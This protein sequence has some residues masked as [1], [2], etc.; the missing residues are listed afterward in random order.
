M[1]TIIPTDRFKQDMDYYERKKKFRHIEEDVGNVV[2]DLVM[3]NLV[4]DEI[5]RFTFKR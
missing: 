2:K 3:G 1:Y 4:G 5:P